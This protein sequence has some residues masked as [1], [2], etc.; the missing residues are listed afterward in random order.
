MVESKRK[1][2]GVA[3]QDISLDAKGLPIEGA[4][5]RMHG[6]I[7]KEVYNFSIQDISHDAKV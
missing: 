1:V 5:S 6:R 2:D 3:P 7:G 4:V